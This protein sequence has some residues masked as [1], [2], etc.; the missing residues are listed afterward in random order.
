MRALS[1]FLVFVAAKLLVLAGREVPPSPWA[2]LAYFWQ[3]AFVALAFAGA[4]QLLRHRPRVAWA[5]YA[6]LAGYAALNVPLACLLSTPLTWPLLR[7]TGGT[8]ADSIDHH[9]TGANI[10][11]IGIVLIAAALL[12]RLVARL[13]LRLRVAALVAAVL[14]LPLGPAA[15]SRV[16]TNGL[17]RNA[18]A[19]LVTSA[20]PRVPAADLAGDWTVGPLG[21][22]RG[23]DLTRLHGRAA[24]RNVVVVHLES[25]G[26]SYLKPYGAAEDPMPRLTA[27][28]AHA[29]LFENAYTTYPETIRSFFAT[30]C[31]IFPAL[32]T[33]AED[34]EPA[35]AP[36]LAELLTEHGY[37]TGLFHPGRFRYLG[38]EEALRNRGYRTR[39]DAGDIGGE[40]E[41]SF[42]IDEASAVRRMLAWIDERPGEPFLLAYLPIAGHHPYDAPG[43]RCFPDDSDLNRYRN[44][45]HY[46]DDSLASLLDGLR[47]RGLEENTLFVICGDHGEA[48]GQHAGNYGH[49]LFLYEENV[50]VPLLIAAPGLIRPARIGRV[51]S[52][53]DL[54]PTVLDLLG[55]PIPGEDQGRSLLSAEPRMALFCTDYSLGLIG[56]R[57]GRWKMIHELDSG[58]SQLFDLR[59]DPRE[60]CDLSGELPER[61]A[62]YREHLLRWAAA[63]KYRVTRKQ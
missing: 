29:L 61:T 37:R 52:L 26:A 32:D 62:V 42:G 54:T 58:R 2:P 50:R 20:L 25:T 43:P 33:R 56:L 55:L 24:R 51:A 63:Q 57:D 48:F 46:A 40:R 23:D 1:L 21:G 10:L 3:D 6:L 19:A 4:D 9:V 12:P 22:T 49:T 31:A 45:L 47:E 18:L 11:R 39:E 5:L 28:S 59:A 30:Q 44:A 53:V 15:L 34:Y 36:A 41:S 38:M 35:H 13:S 16:A 14:L 60:K 7:A 8:I 17:H 27:L